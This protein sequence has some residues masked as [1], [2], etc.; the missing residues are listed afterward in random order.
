MP[1]GVY[2]GHMRSGV[3]ESWNECKQMIQKKTYYKKFDTYIEAEKFARYGPYSEHHASFE[4]CIYTCVN[5][6]TCQYAFWTNEFQVCEI[7]SD[8]KVTQNVLELYAVLSCLRFIQRSPMFHEM[9]IGLYTDSTYA[10]LCCTT[11]GDKC[12]GQGWT[13]SIPNQML[14]KEV[15]ELA[16]LFPNVTIVLTTSFLMKCQEHAEGMQRAKEACSE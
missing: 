15:Y 1:Y 14:V 9:K 12:K 4:K 10:L 11:Y 5:L 16:K 3:V 2:T 13:K 8:G 7:L 6:S